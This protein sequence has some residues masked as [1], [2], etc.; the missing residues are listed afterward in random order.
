MS[1]THQPAPG[2]VEEATGALAGALAGALRSGDEGVAARFR[3]DSWDQRAG[4]LAAVRVLGADVLVPF[5]LTGQPLR[6]DEASLVRAA[7]RAF[8]APRSHGPEGALWGVR[9]AA[10]AAAL[11]R[12]GVDAAGWEGL[13]AAG[14]PSRLAPGWV[15][16][17][18]DLVR[19]STAAHPLLAPEL[20]RRLGDRRLDVERGLVRA[21]LRRDLLSAARLSRWL[22]ALSP[23]GAGPVALPPILDLLEAV[24]ADDPRVRFE[25][26]IARRLNDSH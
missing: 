11:A 21:V 24:G 8:P 23:T 12:L 3:L 22:L 17:A 25:T 20:T 13:A 7:V 10:L 6:Q 2:S 18:A 9:D 14:P 1:I 5:L 4:G 19:L 26:A 15:T 16:L